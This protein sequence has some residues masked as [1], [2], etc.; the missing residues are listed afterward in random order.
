LV[1][2]YP[3]P[4]SASEPSAVALRPGFD[5]NGFSIFGGVSR[6]RP[7]PAAIRLRHGD[8]ETDEARIERIHVFEEVFFQRSLQFYASNSISEGAR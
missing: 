6:K 7:K 1:S 3:G 8:V 2:V 5:D 4:G